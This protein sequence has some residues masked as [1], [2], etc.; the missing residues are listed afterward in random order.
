MLGQAESDLSGKVESEEK[1]I[2]GKVI[3]PSELVTKKP[4]RFQLRNR[5]GALRLS[6]KS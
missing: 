3:N 4:R 2:N 1:V 5:R 6:E